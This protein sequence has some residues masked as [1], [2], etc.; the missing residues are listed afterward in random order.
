MTV[1]KGKLEI[2]LAHLGQSARAAK[3]SEELM[4][5]LDAQ[6][7]KNVVTIAV[8]L[9]NR[10]SGSAGGFGDGAHG[11]GFFSAPGAQPD[12]LKAWRKDAGIR[13]ALR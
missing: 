11:K 9:I 13:S 10:G 2:V 4:A 6:R 8:A 7:T 1:L 5:R 12:D 3:T